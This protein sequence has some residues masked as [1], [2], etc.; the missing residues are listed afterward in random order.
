MFTSI[1]TL[2]RVPVR[3][4]IGTLAVLLAAIEVF[5]DW[6]T[7]V[8]LNI[9]IVYGLPLVLAAAARS[10]RLLWGLTLALICA[11]Y[12]IYAQQIPAGGFSLHE[13]FFINR[14]LATVTALTTAGLLHALII[15]FEAID[16]RGRSAEEASG[17][18]T[19][20]LA[21]MSHD[22]RSPLTSIT[23]LADLMQRSAGNPA[24]A[25]ELRT[26]AED[27]QKSTASLADLVSNA[28][29]ISRLDLGHARLANT[30]FALNEL[31]AEEC[32][33]LK[34]LAEVKSLSLSLRPANPPV[35]LYTD[36]VKL[37]R[38]V[39]NL[40]NNAIKFTD[41]GG[42]TL[43]A[44]IAADRAVVIEVADTGPGIAPE[45]AERIFGEFARLQPGDPSTDGWGLGLAICRRLVGLIGG[46]V[47]VQNAPGGGSVFSVRLPLA[48]K[49]PS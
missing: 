25:L 14:L 7:W 40:L 44:A 11:T 42:V 5:V 19:R 34:P 21:S 3:H 13:P 35:S 24:L 22:L 49:L 28:L 8:Q 41:A 18:K 26:L 9:S 27:L 39:R 20:L 23:L 46:S 15:A 6:T 33:A 2:R 36:R 47:T 31:L 10:R 43:S 32:R 30:Q 29:D 1:F 4:V 37:A 17:R 45:N 12:V 48:A 16:A 38:V